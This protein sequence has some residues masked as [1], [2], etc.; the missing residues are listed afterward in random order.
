[1]K[2]EWVSSRLMPLHQ[3]ARLHSNSML[4]E[5][6]MQIRFIWNF[7][8]IRNL[9]KKPE[10]TEEEAPS[11]SEEISS[12]DFILKH[13]VQPASSPRE[14]AE[15]RTLARVSPSWFPRTDANVESMKGE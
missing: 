10:H 7:F 14:K 12:S 5:E 2:G 1:M 9:K 6:V 4:L 11:L 8:H 3:R 15:H 13:I